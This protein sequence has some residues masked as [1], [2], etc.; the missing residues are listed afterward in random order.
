MTPANPIQAD[1]PE[2]AQNDGATPLYPIPGY[3]HEEC[4]GAAEVFNPPNFGAYCW[5]C[6]RTVPV[7]EVKKI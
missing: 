3:T 2:H 5:R 1:L 4:G 6:G 7:E